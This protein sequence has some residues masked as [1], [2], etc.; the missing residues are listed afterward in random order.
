MTQV[1][2]AFFLD[3]RTLA[4]CQLMLVFHEKPLTVKLLAGEQKATE[5]FCW[6]A[7]SFSL[8]GAL[9]S[10]RWAASFLRGILVEELF[11]VGTKGKRPMCFHLFKICFFPLLIL[12]GI[13]HYRKYLSSG[14]NQ[15][16][17]K[18]KKQKKEVWEGPR[19]WD[20]PRLQPVGTLV[21]STIASAPKG[22]LSP[23]VARLCPGNRIYPSV[24]S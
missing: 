1:F 4:F 14:L 16:S 5:F 12:K 13:Y 24:H 3:V 20:K 22:N 9:S 19:F 18:N 15:K 2:L 23:I 10:V 21:N 6:S 8:G 17:K 11:S 7:P